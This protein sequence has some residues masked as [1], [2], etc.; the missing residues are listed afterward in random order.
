[1]KKNPV[2]FVAGADL[3][4]AKVGFVAEGG[5]AGTTSGASTARPSSGALGYGLRDKG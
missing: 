2:G 3:V 5:A 1:M 4:G